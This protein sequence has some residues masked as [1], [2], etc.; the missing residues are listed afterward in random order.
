[1]VVLCNI[2]THHY[3][4][5][6]TMNYFIRLLEDVLL[7]ELLLDHVLPQDLHQPLYAGDHQELLAQMIV[8]LHDTLA[9]TNNTI[10]M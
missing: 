7:P 2:Y 9:I 6:Y 5:Y 1:M 3:D 4:M 10:C 8:L